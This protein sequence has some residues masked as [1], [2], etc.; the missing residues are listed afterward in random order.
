MICDTGC[1]RTFQINP[2]IN[3]IMMR[4]SCPSLERAKGVDFNNEE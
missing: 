2:I 1:F 4:S 3:G